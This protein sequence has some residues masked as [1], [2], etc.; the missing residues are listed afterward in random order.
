MVA[1]SFFFC[2]SVQKPKF[3]DMFLVV[4]AVGI[5]YRCFILATGK[6]NSQVI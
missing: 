1:S 2:G 4:A 3:D 5:T 6:L